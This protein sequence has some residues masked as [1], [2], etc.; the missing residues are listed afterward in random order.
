M[1]CD[2]T[3]TAEI[4]SKPQIT[5]RCNCDNRLQRFERSLFVV[6]IAES[7]MARE[8]EQWERE[9]AA[10]SCLRTCCWYV[11]MTLTSSWVQ[12]EAHTHTN[13]HR[14]TRT[15]ALSARESAEKRTR[16]RESTEGA[17][18]ARVCARVA[19]C[20]LLLVSFLIALL[21][22]CSCCCC[23]YYYCILASF[24]IPSLSFS[25]LGKN[26]NRNTKRKK[27]K[28]KKKKNLTKLQTNK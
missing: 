17:E 20:Y 28:N 5:N 27:T 25:F 14:H 24:C 15:H 3:V 21:D 8:G 11:S 26:S 22:C 7:G 23:F 6:I 4:T 10:V 2:A 1:W 16:E 9:R 13:A 12:L 19:F 18:R